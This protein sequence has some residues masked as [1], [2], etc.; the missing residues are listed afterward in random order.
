LILLTTDE[1]AG[2]FLQYLDDYYDFLTIGAVVPGAVC[3]CGAGVA[4]AGDWVLAVV[5]C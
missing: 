4:E 5:A 2:V 1:I 3:G